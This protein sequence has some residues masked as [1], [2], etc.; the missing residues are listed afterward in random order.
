MHQARSHTARWPSRCAV[1]SSHRTRL[2]VGAHP[3]ASTRAP[4]GSRG[5][6]PR[7]PD[8]VRLR[9]FIAHLGD[10]HLVV[11]DSWERR[12]VADLPGFPRVH[13]VWAV[14]ELG[15]VYASATGARQVAVVDTKTLSVIGRAA[16]GEYPDGIA[17]APGP[18]RVSVSDERGRADVVI[19]VATNR[20]VDKVALGGE[21]GN[22]VYEPGSG[23][24][25]VAVHERNDL[26][27]IDPA[28][29][30]IIGRYS[31][32]GAAQPHGVSRSM[33]RGGSPSWPQR[34]TRLSP[35]W[36]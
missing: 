20:V 32:T 1:R 18:S 15:R 7:R 19:D 30:K 33:R 14:P 26:V 25:L 10:G 35:S 16:G 11:F 13:G 21:A 4:D 17:Y 24:I 8:A 22:T 34:A 31:V 36:T 23:C 6:A 5:P 3:N 9:L 2:D 28:T 12:V 27:A 29:A